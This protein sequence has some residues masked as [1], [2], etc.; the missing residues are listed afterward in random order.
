MIIEH[1]PLGI[2]PLAKVDHSEAGMDVLVLK[3]RPSLLI[4]VSKHTESAG[5]DLGLASN[6]LV[7]VLVSIVF[8]A[9]PQ[10]APLL[11]FMK[12]NLEMCGAPSK[13]HH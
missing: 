12:K 8:G 3:I 11:C 9:A 2:T 5:L 4:L 6:D 1:T 10:L 13:L 7:L